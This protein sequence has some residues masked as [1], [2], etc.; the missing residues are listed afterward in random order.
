MVLQVVVGKQ[1]KP[2]QGWKQGQ[3]A[4]L[5]H[6][7]SAYSQLEEEKSGSLKNALDETAKTINLIT[8]RPDARL[9]HI[10]GNEQEHFW[11]LPWYRPRLEEQHICDSSCFEPNGLL[12]PREPF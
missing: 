1:L 11:Y 10:L 5:T 2:W 3:Q 9:F 7:R 4:A 6:G 12:L 8:S